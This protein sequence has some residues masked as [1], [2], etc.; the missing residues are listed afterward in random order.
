MGNDFF[1]NKTVRKKE[2]KKASKKE[3]SP[4]LS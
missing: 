3:S 1:S 2:S 4:S